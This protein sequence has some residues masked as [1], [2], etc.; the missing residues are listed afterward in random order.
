MGLGCSEASVSYFETEVLAH[1]FPDVLDLLTRMSIC[2]PVSG[3]LCAAL[4]GDPHAVAKTLA[5]LGRL[6][7]GDLFITQ[8][9][10]SE[11]ETL[12]KLHPLMREALLARLKSEHP[13]PQMKT[14]SRI[15]EFHSARIWPD[16][17]R[18]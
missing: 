14:Y 10:D 16:H 18:H 1:M 7:A 8:I 2:N 5:R 13:E 11:H 12:F 4:L 3:P 17:T 15:L 9:N 6:D